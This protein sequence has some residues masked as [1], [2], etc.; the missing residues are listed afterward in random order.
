MVGHSRESLILL[1]TFSLWLDGKSLGGAEADAPVLV[2]SL[3]AES[4]PPPPF[5][6]GAFHPRHG[7]TLVFLG[8]T[9]TWDMDRQGLLERRIHLAWPHLSL[10]V[11]N[12]AWQGDVVSHQARPR[13][14]YTRKG[15]TQPGSIP[16][17]RE[18]A[19]AGILF[20]N[21]GKM[22]SLGDPEEFAAYEPLVLQLKTLTPRL[23]LVAPTPFFA[24][25]PAASLSAARNRKLADI[26]VEIRAIAGRHQL[27]FVDLFTPF[28]NDPDATNLSSNGVH[29]NEVGHRRIAELFA[30][31]LAF[32]RASS[33]DQSDSLSLAIA[34]KNQLWQQYY[35]PTN[36]AFLFGDRQHVPASRDPV[37]REE[38]W[39]VREIDSLPGLIAEVE[40]DIHRYARNLVH[41][42]G[43]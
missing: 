32:P 22:E 26:V 42:E 3:E 18:K 7:E 41:R 35:R 1:A 16:D 12:L 2:R 31:Q 21:F 11:R 4:P 9:N 43:P 19:R 37:A 38:R 23:V 20:L 24:S 40:T 8:G 28:R 17:H 39:F 30:E 10:R 29:L 15:D 25:G 27:L 14:F 34:Q 13:H 6:K 33:F 5:E 36:W